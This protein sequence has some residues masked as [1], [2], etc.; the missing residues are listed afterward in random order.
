MA[1]RIA[2]IGY[3]KMGRAVE[4]VATARGHG[5]AAIISRNQPLTRDALDG[6][7]VAI[8]F[9]VPDRAVPNAIACV[10]AGVP[11]VVGTTGWSAQLPALE[12]EVE[13]ARGAVLWSPNFSIGVQ[14]LAQLL[15]R[16]AS[17]APARRGFAAHLVETHHQAKKDAPSGTAAMLARVYADAGGG[18][19]PITSVRVGHVPGR[20]ELILDAAYEQ[21]RLVHDARDRRVFADG[22][23]TAAEWLA[24]GG[25]RGI[26]TL[27]DALADDGGASS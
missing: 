20:H 2:L 10:R 16:L 14:L 23:V 3:G 26:F 21:L 11:V 19:L 22:A 5:I 1:L 9:T 15:E 13:Q 6:A 8:E 24:Q 17:L 7:D 27:R 18:A 25:R 12:H 4:Q